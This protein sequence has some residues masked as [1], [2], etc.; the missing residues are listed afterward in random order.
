MNLNPCIR[1]FFYIGINWNFRIAAHILWYEIKGEKKYNIHTTGADELKHVKEAGTDISHSTL[2]MPVSYYL[3]E[4]I[5]TE[6][7]GC[8]FK[9]II[10][11]GC[12][13]GRILCVAAYKGFPKVTG[14]DFSTKLCGDAKD[15]LMHI[16]EKVQL[17]QY[18]IIN[19]DATD[20]PIPYDA[21][22]IFF[23]NPFDEIIMKEVIEN[24][25]SS[26]EKNPRN[27]TI[28]YINPLYK[29][30]FFE[31]GFKQVYHIQKFTY[32]EAIILKRENL[33]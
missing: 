23:F 13:K 7:E 12:G 10:D 1:Y 28:V 22:C 6:F 25:K 15:N 26:L 20:Y 30:L 9:N 2:Y 16:K 14:I 17:L 5:F 33:T 8:K 31:Q 27:I 11:I 32:L 4:K 29:G 18:E 3:I 19:T 21:D 24:I